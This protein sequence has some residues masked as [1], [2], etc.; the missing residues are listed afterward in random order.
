MKGSYIQ[1]EMILNTKEKVIFEDIDEDINVNGSKIKIFA[2]NQVIEGFLNGIDEDL[3]Y[4]ISDSIA[5][6]NEKALK[7]LQKNIKETK[8][9]NKSQYENI[10]NE[11]NSL[12]T[13]SI[14]KYELEDALKNR[15]I[16]NFKRISEELDGMSKEELIKMSKTL[17]DITRL[18]QIISSERETVGGNVT[19]LVLSLKNGTE[20]IY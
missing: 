12:K 8:I 6:Y 7:Q 3:Q 2:Q 11:I 19:L 15:K 4:E 1:F 20:K 13:N 16:D 5:E 10:S 14:I 9:L 17:I 18:K